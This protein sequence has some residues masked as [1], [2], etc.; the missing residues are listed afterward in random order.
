MTAQAILLPLF[1]QVALTLVMLGLTAYSRLASVRR[2]ETKLKDIA[3]RQSNWPE[4]ATKYGNSYEN[5]F[6]LPV[7]FYVGVISAYVLGKADLVLVILSWLFVATRL[8]HAY[9]HTTSNHVGRR[10]NAFAAGFAVLVVMWIILG[11]RI[12]TGLP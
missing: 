7:L 8:C 10:F 3:L 4:Q 2:G 6:Q 9:I 1:V 5:Q 12:L 11:M